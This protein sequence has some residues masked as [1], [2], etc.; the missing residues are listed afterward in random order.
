MTGQLDDRGLNHR[1]S[2]TPLSTSE[3]NFCHFC[4]LIPPTF[5]H[6]ST[7]LGQSTTKTPPE[8]RNR[9]PWKQPHKTR[10][11]LDHSKRLKSPI[12][13]TPIRGS[14]SELTFTTLD[15]NLEKPLK[16]SPSSWYT[17]I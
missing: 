2:P 17:G 1:Q 7:K 11:R 10:G 5:E 4:R 9:T 3:L 6:F 14:S 16:K 8:L 13:Y 15:K 12:Y